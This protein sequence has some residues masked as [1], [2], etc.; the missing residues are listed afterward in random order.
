MLRQQLVRVVARLGSGRLRQLESVAQLAQGKGWGS[1]TVA[2]EVSAV[3]KLL[4][5]LAEGELVVLDVGANIGAWTRQALTQLP[6]AQIHVFEPGAAA[7]AEL[8]LAFSGN[9]RVSLNRLALGLTDQEA[10]LYANAP[11]SGLASLTRRRLNHLGIA[12]SHQEPVEVQ[13][14]ES[15]AKAAGID[16]VDILKLDVEGHELD[17]LNGAGQLLMGVRLIQFEFGGCNIDTRTF[18]QDF[19]YLLSGKFR[20]YRL[21]PGGLFPIESYTEHD[22]TFTT[23]NYFAARH[24]T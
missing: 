24:L 21:G 15:W 10:V 2:E 11:G 17:V 22:E 19:W 5:D 18:F 14:L 13:S 7:F 20:L 8:S 9:P 16:A 6:Q 12:F 1:A 23:T 4:A 3:R